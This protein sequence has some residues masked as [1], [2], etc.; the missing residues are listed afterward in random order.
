VIT[1]AN[2]IAALVEEPIPLAAGDVVVTASIGI[3]VATGI[4]DRPE[5]LLRDADAAVYQAK[6]R[7]RRRFELFDHEM[8][9]RAVQRT[10][11][12][13]ELRRGI[14]NDELR[15]LYQP[16]V[17]PLDMRV[18]AVEALVRWEHPRRG[19]LQPNQFIP[20]AEETLLINDLGSWVLRE[21][22]VQS[23]RWERALP[24]HRTLS[25]AVNLSAR[26]LPYPDFEDT[27]R[28]I[29]EDT[30]AEPK[31]LWFELTETALMDPAP[32]VPEVL[33]RLRELGFHLAIDDFG[34]GYSSLS[35]LK[36]FRFDELKIDRGFVHG[37]GLDA[38]DSS[39]VAAIVSLARNLRLLAVAEGVETAE[40]SDALQALGCDLAQ[41]FYFSGPVPAG[42]R[43]PVL[44]SA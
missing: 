12:E 29:L 10:R 35:H 3:A 27:V 1:I 8:R 2:R 28:Q 19:L 22:C 16:I 13:N 4:S 18:D 11:T 26:Q 34:T 39:I 21:V 14:E 38:E 30:G 20:V 7:G 41:G 33:S 17:N 15:L 9:A 23:V 5:T 31:N 24:D 6:A 43:E 40:Q 25:I 44:R 32:Q 36:E 37:L 42:R